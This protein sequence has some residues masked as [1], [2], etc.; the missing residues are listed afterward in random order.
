MLVKVSA[1]NFRSINKKQTFSMEAGKA[2]NFSERTTRI[3]GT[4]IL[5]FKAVYGPNASGK[6]NLIRIFEFMRTAVIRG[7]PGASTMDYCRLQDN[8][9]NQLSKFEIE[10]VLDGKYYEYG[11]ETL[12]SEGRFTR[13]WLIEHKAQ[14]SRQIFYRNIEQETFEIQ[15]FHNVAVNERL[16]IYADDI[17]ADK[18]VLFLRAM[19]QN[20]DSL[21]TD[22]SKIK[23][24]KTL[25]CWFRDCL[26]VHY[27]DDPLTEFTY[28][29]D[30]KGCA[31]AEEILKKMDTGISGLSIY[32]VPTEKVMSQIP[33]ELFQ[34][35][36]NRLTEQKI[37]NGTP[38]DEPPSVVVRNMEGHDMFMIELRDEDVICKTLK[39]NH[40]HS[41]SLFTLRDESD[42]TVRLLDLV[43]I[44]LSDAENT[45]Y[46]LDEINRCLHPMITKQF[47]KYFLQLA[48][49]RNIQ[50]IATTHETDL[51]DLG[52]LRQDEIGF[53][54][55]QEED[56]SSRIFGLEDYGARFDKKIRS[57]YMKGQYEAIPRLES[58]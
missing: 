50:L 22:E 51:M 32:D 23:I 20:K 24:F 25:Y 34:E 18:K 3:A 31:A 54:Q 40:R 36:V 9:V 30:S 56:G 38:D 33:K 10:V 42:G 39:F 2:R 6:S 45:V 46:V 12:L 41:N 29:F 57:A 7:I 1:S 55:K 37:Q 49:E 15:D 16:R 4:K 43:E 35:I 17:K 19:N 28:F 14:S 48:T 21:Y 47:V 52:L 44:L 5:K 26:S 8:N 13:E 11:F 58:I 53:V 27:P